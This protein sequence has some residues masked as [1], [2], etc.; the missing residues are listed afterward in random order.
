VT[1]I[2]ATLHLAADPRSV[3]DARQLIR[4]VCLDAAVAEDLCDTA[5]LLASETVTNAIIHGAG[6]IRMTVHL[7]A[8]LVRVEVADASND[9]PVVR[10]LATHST[11]GRGMSI[12]ARAASDW[13]VIDLDAGKVV[14]FEV[15]R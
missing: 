5:T 7:D 10:A 12:V 2:S 9:R 6:E 3:R 1:P 8:D 13:G 11:S 15:A 14:W 4:S